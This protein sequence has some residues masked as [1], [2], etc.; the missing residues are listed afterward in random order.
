MRL[1]RHCGLPFILDHCRDKLL[2][3]AT[4]VQLIPHVHCRDR[5]IIVV[6][7]VLLISQVLFSLTVTT[8][9]EM[10]RRSL[11]LLPCKVSQQLSVVFL[12]ILL[13]LCRD[14]AY[15][16]STLLMLIDFSFVMTILR[17]S[18]H[19]IHLALAKSA[20]FLTFFL[21]FLLSIPAKHR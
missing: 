9:F 12:G 15:I 5:F 6:T 20:A 11:C 8:K 10:S 7:N 19:Y 1:S 18:R 13:N 4:N 3:V 21:L 14:R 16:V 17:L 2:I